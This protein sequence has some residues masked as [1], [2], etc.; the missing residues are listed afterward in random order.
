ME[1]GKASVFYQVVR[2]WEKKSRKFENAK[3]YFLVFLLVELESE[4]VDAI[5]AKIDVPEGVYVDY[6]LD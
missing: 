2:F 6:C 3:I 5:E 4:A 1:Y